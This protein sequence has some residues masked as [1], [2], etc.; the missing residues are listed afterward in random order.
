VFKKEGATGPLPY[1]RRVKSQN[2]W[3]EVEQAYSRM[4]TE[5]P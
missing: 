5:E 1:S 3:Q 2:Q 4:A